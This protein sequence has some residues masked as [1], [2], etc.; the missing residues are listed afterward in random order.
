[1]RTDLPDGFFEWSLT[2]FLTVIFF[3]L[4]FCFGYA[5]HH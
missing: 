4:G 5:L 3:A 1:M 2:L